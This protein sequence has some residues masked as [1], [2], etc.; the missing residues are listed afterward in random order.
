M[1]EPLHV[2]VAKPDHR[3][4]STRFSAHVLP[5]NLAPGSFA[6]LTDSL[7]IISPECCFLLAANFFSLPELVCAANDLCAVYR[8]DAISALGQSGRPALT[9]KNAISHYL[10]H[11]YNIK[12]LKTARQALKYAVN[13]SNSPMESKLAALF[14]LPLKLGGFGLPVPLMNPAIELT[15]NAASF[16]GRDNCRVDMLWETP[17]V[18]LEYDSNLTHLSREQ[19]HYDKKRAT[20][21]AM[22]GYT[23]ISVTADHLNSHSSIDKLCLDLRSALGIRTHM[24]RFNKYSKIRHETVEKIIYRRAGVQKLRL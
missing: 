4:I 18:V 2:L 10:D 24:D 20:S 13:C 3:H 23:V 11:S 6:K 8:S 17:K 7:Y 22:S 14:C 19:H 12:G 16:L 21:L 9:D 5:R 1:E 15:L